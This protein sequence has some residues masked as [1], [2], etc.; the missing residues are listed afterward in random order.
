MGTWCC[1]INF[2]LARNLTRQLNLAYQE[3]VG[4]GIW[5][6]YSESGKPA[7]IVPLY[8]TNPRKPGLFNSLDKPQSEE[9]EG[10][11]KAGVGVVLSAILGIG[12]IAAYAYA[13]GKCVQDI[14]D[15][16]NQSAACDAVSSG[17]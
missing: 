3:G 2:S 5:T 6:Y 8:S 11:P 4:G 15:G 1:S 17:W 10:E 12:V 14:G 9:D 13:T 7:I 16:I